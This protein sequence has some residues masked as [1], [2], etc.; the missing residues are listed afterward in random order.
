MIYH[1]GKA[2]VT[3]QDSS[4]NSPRYCDSLTLLEGLQKAPPA[5]SID[6][7]QPKQ[8]KPET[9]RKP[10]QDT[11]TPTGAHVMREVSSFAFALLFS[12]ALASKCVLPRNKIQQ[13]VEEDGVSS[14]YMMAFTRN[15]FSI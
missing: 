7:A 3:S 11:T 4:A 8:T 5:L 14:T 6:S 12:C 1:G 10:A 13:D 15:A 9:Q 2:P